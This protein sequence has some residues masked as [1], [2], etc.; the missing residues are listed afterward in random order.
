M[1]FWPC[2]VWIVC[3]FAYVIFCIN[4]ANFYFWMEIKDI[5]DI[6][7]HAERGNVMN[8]F[9]KSLYLFV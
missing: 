4:V 8:T 1:L 7:G 5:M 3:D 9:K 6:M 2:C